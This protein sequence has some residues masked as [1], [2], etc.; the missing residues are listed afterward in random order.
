MDIEL[1]ELDEAAEGQQDLDVWNPWNIPL[2]VPI[3][4]PS[5]DE[6]PEQERRFED[7]VARRE[8]KPTG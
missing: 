4:T 6:W 2:A 5:L 7:G 1:T 8:G 3:P